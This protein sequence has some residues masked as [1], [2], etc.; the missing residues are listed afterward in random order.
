MKVK[1]IVV[2]EEFVKDLRSLYEGA[3][4]YYGAA[5]NIVQPIW[6]R[7]AKSVVEEEKE[8]QEIK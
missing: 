3:E 1:F 7:I 4:R 6:E 2:N 5:Q 8:I